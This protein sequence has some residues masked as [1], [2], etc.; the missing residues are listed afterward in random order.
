MGEA[1]MDVGIIPE[2]TARVLISVNAVDDNEPLV[3][4]EVYLQEGTEFWVPKVGET[5]EPA[6]EGEPYVVT[7]ALPGTYTAVACRSDD[8]MVRQIIELG[9]EQEEL[10]VFLRMPKGTAAVS[11]ELLTDYRQP[12]LMWR[13]DEKVTAHITPS[14][15]GTYRVENLPAGR[16]SIGRYLIGKSA[17]LAQFTLYEDETRIVDIDTSHWSVSE[18]ASLHTQVVNEKGVP[19]AGAEV[20]LDG[21]TGVIEPLTRVGEGQFFV[22]DPGEYA[23]HAAYPRYREAAQR[24]WLEARG[25]GLTPTADSMVIVRLEKK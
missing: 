25:I 6:Q 15:D 2:H 21:H 12:L 8:V 13:S 4:L 7:N 20:W 10:N 18:K 19:L 3:G 17:P 5:A 16:Y 23:L 14:Y 9:A 1:D 24:I 11:G 22:A